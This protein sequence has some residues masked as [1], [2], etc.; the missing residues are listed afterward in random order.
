MSERI[1]EA[2]VT[3]LAMDAPPSR[4]P[5]PPAGIRLALMRADNVPLHYYRYLYE[6]VGRRWLWIER[7][8]LS[9]EALAAEVHARGVE[10]FVAYANGTPAGFYELDFHRRDTANLS[11]FGLMP[12]W[13][14]RKIGPWLLGTAISEAFSHRIADLTVNTCTFDHPAALPLYQRLG[15]AP[16][17]Q[18]KRQVSVPAGVPIPHHIA[19]RLSA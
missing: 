3:Y 6:E 4:L 7:L 1:V 5:P 2:V 13:I 9:D 16:V 19:A 12:E 15:F 17:G 8:G 18:R 14:G 10:I 11:Y